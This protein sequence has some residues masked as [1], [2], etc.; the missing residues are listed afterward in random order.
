MLQRAV[1][2]GALVAGLWLCGP[3][4][5]AV[6]PTRIMTL[7]DSVTVNPQDM[8]D[9]SARVPA[10]VAVQAAAA[11]AFTGP[12]RVSPDH[13][14]FVDAAGKPFFWL[15]DT[16]WALPVVLNPADA[17]L[18]LR[19][20]GA[21]GFT[22]VQC[23][24]AWS[25]GTGDNKNT[26][27]PNHAGERPWLNDN[28]ATPNDAFFRHVDYLVDTANREGIVLA[29]LPSWS[30]F[31]DNGLLNNGNAR[32]YGRWLGARYRSRPNIIWVIGGDIESKRDGTPYLELA[33]GLK[34]TDGTHLVTYHNQAWSSDQKGADPWLDFN[35]SQAW[36]RYYIPAMVA[37]DYILK[38]PKPTVMGEVA[39]EDGPQYPNK[40]INPLAIRKQAWWTYLSGGGHTYGN[41]SVW[42]FGKYYDPGTSPDW[43]KALDSQGAFHVGKARTILAS[44]S[45]WTLVPDQKIV[46]NE[47]VSDNIWKYGSGV[48]AARLGDGSGALVYL[49]DPKAIN[50][51]LGRIAAKGALRASWINPITGEATVIGDVGSSGT[52]SFTTPAGLTDAVLALDRS[53]PAATPPA[54]PPTSRS[55]S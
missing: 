18:Y 8:A 7:G 5:A 26:P 48:V 31:V 40:P 12:L 37:H 3:A 14:G 9:F 30:N 50:V 1:A 39:Y 43:K 49:P 52:R 15:G 42:G 47:A 51:D 20:R 41:N 23:V 16:A 2:V 29:M 24:L 17:D 19:N 55:G 11:L 25:G 45:W 54:T 10:L 46:P 34:E 22:V 36:G 38:P 13:R 6:P 33:A 28:P 35:M 27:H 44:R 32:A 21:K 53:G 4:G